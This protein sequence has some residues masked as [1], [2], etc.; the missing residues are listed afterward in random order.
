MGIFTFVMRYLA[1]LNTRAPFHADSD[2]QRRKRQKA[3]AFGRVEP[4]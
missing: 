2:C 1:E 3:V 4:G